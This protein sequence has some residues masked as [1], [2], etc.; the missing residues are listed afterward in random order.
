[1]WGRMILKRCV[2]AILHGEKPGALSY[3]HLAP[4][5]RWF[6]CIFEVIYFRLG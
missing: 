6:E 1:M 5:P 3:R 4:V 2:E